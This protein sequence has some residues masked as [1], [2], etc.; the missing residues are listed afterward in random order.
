MEKQIKE[1]AKILRD[2]NGM[3]YP[4]NYFIADAKILY[5]AGYR[6]ASEVALEVIGEVEALANKHIS[7]LN[8]IQL[9]SPSVAAGGKHA[10]EL[11]LNLLAELKN[12]YTEDG[13]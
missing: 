12:K 8:T 7:V 10:F 2:A 4:E 6:R 9:I 1:M 3:S 11:V 5:R 13:E